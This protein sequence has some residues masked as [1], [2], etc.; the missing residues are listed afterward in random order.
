[1]NIRFLKYR[2]LIRPKEQMNEYLS[3]LMGQLDQ[4]VL[5]DKALNCTVK[6][7]GSPL[8]VLGGIPA[9]VTD[10]SPLWDTNLGKWT[11]EAI[12][13]GYRSG[14]TEEFQ[15]RGLVQDGR[16]TAPGG[17]SYGSAGIIVNC[18]IVFRLL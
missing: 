3:Q 8:N 10:Y 2:S 15:I 4:I 7:Q 14:V 5:K 12:D 17:G 16:I 13:N 18:P 9:I 6:G 1:M 11:Q